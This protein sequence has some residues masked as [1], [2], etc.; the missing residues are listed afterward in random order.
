MYENGKGSYNGKQMQNINHAYAPMDRKRS[1]MNTEMDVTTKVRFHTAIAPTNSVS[2]TQL[3]RDKQLTGAVPMH[4]E[5]GLSSMYYTYMIQ[6]SSDCEKQMYDHDS[7]VVVK[8]KKSKAKFQGLRWH[9]DRQLTRIG[10]MQF[11]SSPAKGPRRGRSAASKEVL[12]QQGD[13][14]N[15]ALPKEH[16]TLDQ[17]LGPVVHD[18]LVNFS[19]AEEERRNSTQVSK[20]AY[21][22]NLKKRVNSSVLGAIS[23]SP[24]KKPPNELVNDNVIFLTRYAQKHDDQYSN[25][26]SLWMDRNKTGKRAS[27]PP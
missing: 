6:Q 11:T 1:M 17:K 13:F 26:P 3:F 19:G 22:D 8:G 24:V 23:A 10:A 16:D 7:T 9:P 2:L 4:S 14:I 20:I 25:L 5:P 18:A 12:V 21:D 15:P 27:L